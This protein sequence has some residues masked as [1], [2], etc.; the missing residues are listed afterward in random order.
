MLSQRESQAIREA[1]ACAYAIELRS[2]HGDGEPSDAQVIW[3]ALVVCIQEGDRAASG[4][5]PGAPSGPRTSW[6]RYRTEHEGDE[7]DHDNK[8]AAL[9]TDH[10]TVFHAMRKC[11]KPPHWLVLATMASAEA[12]HIRMEDALA[13][14]SPAVLCQRAMDIRELA[15]D[16]IVLT[17]GN[18][19]S[20]VQKK[21]GARS[22]ANERT[23]RKMPSSIPT[24]TP[25][26]GS[27]PSGCA[28]R[29]DQFGRVKRPKEAA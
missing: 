6:A 17:L 15:L 10:S 12:R 20:D 4:R 9:L 21:V 1:F 8:E 2:R 24:P 28:L 14:L 23:A 11:V 22:P 29:L 27:D 13:E 19:L 26:R 18:V 25:K 5:T 16:A 3:R 7:L